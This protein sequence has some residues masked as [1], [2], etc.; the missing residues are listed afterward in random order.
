MSTAV[1]IL[2]FGTCP[3]VEKTVRRA[4]RDRTGTRMASAREPGSPQ[5]ASGGSA[6][7]R[8]TG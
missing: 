6:D 2:Y 8:T 4:A 5:H 1:E 7:R 3:N